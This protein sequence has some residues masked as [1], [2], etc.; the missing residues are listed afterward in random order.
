MPEDKQEYETYNLNSER[1]DKLDS[2][3]DYY[4]EDVYSTWSNKSSKDGWLGFL[5]NN[6]L[7]FVVIAAAAVILIFLYQRLPK[8][9]LDKPNDD[10]IAA[11]EANVKKLE[12][13]ISQFEGR[14]VSGEEPAVEKEEFSQLLSRVDR[15]EENSFK[16]TGEIEAR[17][18]A[19]ERGKKSPKTKPSTVG[20]TG[21]AAVKKSSATEPSAAAK[22]TASVALHTVRPKETLYGIAKRY[23]LTV[24][25]LM[26]LNNLSPNSTIYPGDKLKVGP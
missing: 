3:N 20:G 26:K 15:L 9:P 4:E 25:E 18:E 10:R 21:T 22:D 1:E 5:K 16:R 11:L 13:R 2:Q 8:A 6:L 7:L 14:P 23:K 19:I 17:L 24:K 12:D